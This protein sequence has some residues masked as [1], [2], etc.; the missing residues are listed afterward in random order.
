M[1]DFDL[2]IRDGTVIDG[3]GSQPRRA[4]VAVLGDRIADVGVV[5]GRGRREVD[6]AGALVAPGFVDLHT[7][8]DGQATWDG[9]LQPSSWHGVTTVVVGNCGVGFAPVKPEHRGRVVEL[10]E[11]V[12]DIPGV[13]LTEGLSWEWESFPAFLTALEARPH[14]MDIGTQVPHAPL[15]V[16]AM[17]DRAMAHEQ[18]TRGEIE[19]MAG[20]AR[21]AVQAGALGFTTSRTL[22]HRSI[23]GEL[24]PSYDV[25]AD[26][27]T[28]IAVA[29]GS[30]GTGVLQLVTDFTDPDDDFELMRRM[31][32][33]SGRPLSVS[34]SQVQ[35][36]PQTYRRVLD[37]LEQARGD[38]LAITGQVATRG[39]G[40]LLGLQCTLH[41]F[42]SNPAWQRLAHL[43]Y[44]EQARLMARPETKAAILAAQDSQAPSN[45]LGGS[46]IYLYDM[47]YELTDPPDYEPEPGMSLGARA[48][49]AGQSPEELAYDV[50]RADAGRGMIY[51]PIANYTYGSLDAVREMLVHPYTVP[52]LS[53]GGAHVGTVCD[54]SF[55]TMLLQYWA[56]DRRRDRLDL[57]FVIKKQSRDTASAVG[58]LD[59]GLLA[60]GYKAD[61]NVIDLDRIRLH[62]PEMSFDLPAGGGRLLQRAD[63]YRHTFVSGV[64]TYR[65]GQPTGQLPGA[66]VRG[67]RAAPAATA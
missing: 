42:M 27:L 56:R 50:I 47:M 13:A 54:A 64:E 5:A 25:D 45:R 41:P 17:G 62:R 31:V 44:A 16:Y 11:G 15:R 60:P 19:T 4:D 9:F 2:I 14:D 7:H 35:E 12:E 40:M 39:I 65:D 37:L 61:L 26:E 46:S 30:T 24:I 28:A 38:G 34:V 53:D 21:E 48:A 23:S 57:P 59:R 8:Y 51:L 29:V 58:L 43:P 67:A 22:A 52:G 6:A 66:V 63:G 32:R 36:R 49:R 55:P 10:M 3:S 33:E 20:L 18:A 1:V